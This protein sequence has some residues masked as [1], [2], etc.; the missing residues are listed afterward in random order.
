MLHAISFFAGSYSKPLTPRARLNSAIENSK[1]TLE[2]L[3]NTKLSATRSEVEIQLSA[4]RQ[5]ILN[6]IR[7]NNRDDLRLLHADILEQSPENKIILLP[8]IKNE[9]IRK[10]VREL[11]RSEWRQ[12]TAD[13][14]TG[15]PVKTYARYFID[16]LRVVN[17][18]LGRYAETAALLFS[19]M[20]YSTRGGK[21][22]SIE[23]ELYDLLLEA[24]LLFKERTPVAYSSRIYLDSEISEDPG[25]QIWLERLRAR[26]VV[27][28]CIRENKQI[29]TQLYLLSTIKEEF[30][31]D[32]VLETYKILF[33]KINSQITSRYR[34][35][36][37]NNYLTP[38]KMKRLIAHLPDLAVQVEKFY[39]RSFE[40]KISIED[41]PKAKS[42][43]LQY[44]SLFLDSG[45][46]TEYQNEIAKL[47]KEGLEILTRPVVEEMQIDDVDSKKPRLLTFD[48][49]SR[50]SDAGGA[51]VN[52]IERFGL[53]V[54]FI[55]VLIVLFIKKGDVF[56]TVL[57]RFFKSRGKKNKAVQFD[58]VEPIDRS[59]RL[60]GVSRGK[61][62]G[63]DTGKSNHSGSKKKVMNL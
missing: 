48:F 33:S 63:S 29:E 40:D 4:N 52:R 53:T 45:I 47:D 34:E 42:V 28:Y 25:F 49:G 31:N 41:I 43:F 27:Q 32:S 12:W 13:T 56:R 60:R 30:L 8:E 17:F 23:E 20:Y 19:A 9:I 15:K 51:L 11:S 18:D 59:P 24:D 22:F 61:G 62:S 16:E 58:N 2:N 21:S 3:T 35:E 1:D 6:A 37:R 39:Q 7:F 54:I 36:L 10:L 50:V 14:K 26:F 55:L 46:L 44:S 38:E 57:S 5:R